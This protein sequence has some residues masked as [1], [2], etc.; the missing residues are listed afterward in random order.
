MNKVYN[1]VLITCDDVA[2]R[3]IR[4]YIL[5]SLEYTRIKYI[6]KINKI[7]HHEILTEDTFFESYLKTAMYDEEIYFSNNE[8]NLDSLI[9][10][11]E[12]SEK[13]SNLSLEQKEIIRL[14]ILGYTNKKIA[15]LLGVSEKT[16]NRRLKTIRIIFREHTD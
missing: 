14:R 8:N 7:K 11:T 12:L 2:S 1:G 13:Y 15:Q 10:H 9:E 5:R 6:D 4:G 16:I 3:K